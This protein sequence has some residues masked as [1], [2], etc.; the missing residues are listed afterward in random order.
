ILI[1]SKAYLIE[2]RQNELKNLFLQRIKIVFTE[3]PENPTGKEDAAT[4]INKKST[5]WHSIQ[6]KIVVPE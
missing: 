3:N 1:V 2:R 4:V 5:N 6:T